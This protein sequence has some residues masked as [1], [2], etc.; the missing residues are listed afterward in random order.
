MRQNPPSGTIT[1][2]F[3]DIEG[4]TKLWE[5]SADT[6]RQALACHDEIVRAGIEANGGFIF[7]TIGDAFC[8]AFA[9]AP[10]AVAAALDAQQSLLAETWEI[11][12]PL[13]ARMALHTGAAEERGGDYYGQPLNRVARLLSA[14]HGGQ[15]LVSLV[16]QELV[17]DAL[18]PGALLI[19]LGDASLKDL[20]RTER[21][22]QL[23]HI[24]LPADFPP[25]RTLNSGELP[26]NL[27]QQ[28]TSFIGRDKEL[29]DVKALLDK[30][31]LLTLVGPGGAGKTRLALQAAADLLDGTGDGVWLV[32]LAPLSDSAL[33][34]GAVAQALNIKE[35]PGQPIQKSLGDALK[36]K[37]LLIVLD[38]C[39]HVIAACATLAADLLRNC[40]GIHILATSREPL[41]LSGEQT[42][43]IPSLSVPPAA[44][45]NHTLTADVLSQY[46]S[47]RLFIERAQA[48]QPTFSVTDQNAPA[49]AQVCAHLDGIPL[50]IELAAAR[51]RSMPVE[52]VNARLDQRFRLLTGGSRANLPRQQTLR[53]LIDWSY[54]LLNEQERVMLTRLSVFAGGCTLDAAES[55]CAGGNIDEWQ[56][57]DLLA[58][59]T[60]KSLTVYEDPGEGPGAPA[61]YGLLETIR[62]YAQERLTESGEAAAD[63]ARARHSD[64]CLALAQEA[65]PQ[66]IGPEAAEW[67]ARL[68][69]EHD[70]FRAALTSCEQAQ[71]ERQGECAKLA[72][73]IAA[74]LAR[75]WYVHGHYSEGRR[76]IASTLRQVDALLS[77]PAES[78]DLLQGRAK[79][80]T[81]AGPLAAMQSDYTAARDF[82][83]SGLDIF[84]RIDD[85]PNIARA[86]SGLGNV[87]ST[88]SDYTAARPLYEESL[89]LRRQLQD[90]AGIAYTLNG[91]AFMANRQGDHAAA[92][93]YYA[94]CVD[95]FREG[96]NQAGLA[97]SLDG[98][99]NILS[100]QGELEESSAMHQESLEIRRS[101]GDLQGISD[102]L[103]GMAFTANVQG[104]YER[105]RAYLEES[106]Q[107]RKSIG[108]TR[109]IASVLGN[110]SESAH[111]LGDYPAARRLMLES[112]A[113]ARDLD[114]SDCAYSVLSDFGDHATQE[115]DYT[116]AQQCLSDAWRIAEESKDSSKIAWTLLFLGNL[117]S[118]QRDLACARASLLK[119]YDLV[120]GSLGRL[121]IIRFLEAMAD[122]SAAARQTERSI[123]LRSAAALLRTQV[124]TPLCPTERKKHQQAITTARADMSDTAFDTAWATGQNM[125]QQQAVNLAL[126]TSPANP[127]CA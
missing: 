44:S 29:I 13:R 104:E 56:V 107:I 84:R 117:A 101:M 60:D 102:S 31:R 85:T 70:N 58:S 20:S 46:D 21:V 59:L 16:T 95:R 106:L 4:S 114:D 89:R 6:M 73:Q 71:A 64:W 81:G 19:D 8:A 51:V 18:P 36:A 124:G 38:N 113:L 97:N 122:L 34:T 96:G 5:S 37:T 66:L 40:P 7:K 112:L 45:K 52:Q 65:E 50:A 119:S 28:P 105:A 17:R 83:Q 57:L 115:G 123:I 15:T 26:N 126:A 33:V 41:G 94:E 109:G 63:T 27:P 23:N 12:P 11:D 22:Y 55:V 93:A 82:F 120:Q 69:T 127:P 61:R 10:E 90:Q 49:V 77:D 87:L 88:Q 35:A 2:L 54:D 75:F 92:R 111:G 103:N 121:F 91:L 108:N 98:L 100:L 1:F 48:V 14:G 3:T 62:Q 42:Y 47:V 9:T 99:A 118:A 76:W 32:E 86:L 39:E 53:A 24:D 125:P 25:L 74:T 79:A 43:R 110:L 116:V 67:L 68:E 80:L 72:L 30:T 78:D